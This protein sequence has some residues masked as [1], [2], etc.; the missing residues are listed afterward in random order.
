MTA[1]DIEILA[2]DFTIKSLKS[3][4]KLLPDFYKI[5]FKEGIE[6]YIESASK[7]EVSWDEAWD[8]YLKN[9]K[10]ANFTDYVAELK[11]TTH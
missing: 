7:E 1:E 5:G 4:D 9:A 8:R 11:K 6:R 3:V 10:C 2:E